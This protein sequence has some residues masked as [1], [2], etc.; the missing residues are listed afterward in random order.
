MGSFDGAEVCELVGL[1]ILS[2]LKKD[3]NNKD[4]G[5]YRDD[6]LIVLKN[7]NGQKT[8]NARKSIVKTFKEVG[9]QIEIETGLKEV[10]FLDIT[11][12]LVNGTY[13]PYKKPNDKL[14]YIHK[15]SNHPPQVLKQLPQSINDRLSNNSSN[16]EVFNRA[17]R[18]YETALEESDLKT[19]LKFNKK[20]KKTRNRKRNI[21]WFNPPYNK[22]VVTNIA[23]LFLQLLDKHF[24]R[25]H[26]LHKIFNRNT[27]KVSYGCTNNVSQIIKS[28]NNKVLNKNEKKP[29]KCN[30]R[31]K[32]QC[33]LNGNCQIESVMYNCD[34]KSNS[35][36][37]K[38]YI[39]ITE[40]P[41][42]SRNSNHKYSFNKEERKN[43][44]ALSKHVWE[45][46]YKN[47]MPDL[48]WSIL[49]QIPAYSNVSKKCNL[50]LREKLEI[51][52]YENKEELLNK[53]NELISKCRHE[54]K[55]LLKN[56]KNK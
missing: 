2:I 26:K 28:H 53:N 49:K 55:Y 1:Y 43:D 42:K 31:N 21:I 10:N 41:W 9:F 5:I 45:L 23:K 16:E 15:L 50:C 46:K 48:K 56:F 47:E 6:G 17:K 14:Q 37:T 39:G 4:M 24:P 12:N 51:I 7:Y 25:T 35:T 18:E 38:K 36:P 34:I 44:T 29:P 8:D 33:P 52:K 3:F 22:N 40:G 11:L 20:G 54:N 19:E 27:V 32:D 13:R 30:C